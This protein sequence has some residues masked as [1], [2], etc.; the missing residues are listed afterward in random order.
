MREESGL[1]ALWLILLAVFVIWNIVD[2]AT[3][4]HDVKELR[5]QVQELQK[6]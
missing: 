4:E 1:T 3:L 2:I 5:T 6:D